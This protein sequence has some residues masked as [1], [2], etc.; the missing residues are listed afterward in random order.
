M[1]LIEDAKSE[2]DAQVMR[3]ILLLSSTCTLRYEV[4]FIRCFISR[5]FYQSE[6]TTLVASYK[7]KMIVNCIM[8]LK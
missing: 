2:E 4:S 1:E 8:L 3:L 5:A 6:K 7:L